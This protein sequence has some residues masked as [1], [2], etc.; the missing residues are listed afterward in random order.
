M[1][2]DRE[3]LVYEI[4][5]ENV[6]EKFY[7][8]NNVFDFSDYPLDSVELHSKFFN[9]VKNN[10]VFDFSDYLLNSMELHSKFF[11]PVKKKLLAK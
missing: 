4:K 9:P 10:N 6:Y 11:N 8:D 7:Q 3:S 2:T 1:L 5:T